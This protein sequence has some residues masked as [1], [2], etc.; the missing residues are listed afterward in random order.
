MEYFENIVLKILECEGKWVRQN[1]KVDLTSHEKKMIG[2]PTAPRPDIDIV[3]YILSTNT[4]ELWEVKSYIDSVGVQFRDI[5][6]KP[7]V[8]EGRYKLLTS[9]K[10][11]TVLANRLTADWIKQGL[12]KKKPK[13]KFG[14]ATGKIRNGDEDKIRKYC[15]KQKWRLLTPSD[16]KDGLEKLASTSYENDPYTIAAKIIFRN[17]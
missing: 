4:I 12:I 9:K 17:P 11:Q 14:L 13:V 2:K 16:I 8:Q 1:V 10:Y 5:Q 3:T 7:G 6:I 15:D